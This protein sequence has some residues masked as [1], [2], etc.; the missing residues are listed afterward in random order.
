MSEEILFFYFLSL[1][2]ADLHVLV[3]LFDLHT[4]KK[5]QLFLSL[6]TQIPDIFVPFFLGLLN[7]HLLKTT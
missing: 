7:K 5:P 6:V 1:V 2:L 4:I 3:Q